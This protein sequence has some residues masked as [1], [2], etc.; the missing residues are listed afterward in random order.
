MQFDRVYAAKK[1]Q[2][3]ENETSHHLKRSVDLRP[4]AAQA[5]LWPWV[6]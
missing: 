3:K 2:T 5:V 1:K 4:K 6:P